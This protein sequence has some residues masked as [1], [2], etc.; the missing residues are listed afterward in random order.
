MPAEY[1]Y[2]CGHSADHSTAAFDMLPEPIRRFAQAADASY[3]GACIA[4]NRVF[5]DAAILA[6]LEKMDR[7][8][9]DRFL[10]ELNHARR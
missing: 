1:L 10:A 4:K 3:C 6:H 8:F 2:P 7:Q 9:S 5:G